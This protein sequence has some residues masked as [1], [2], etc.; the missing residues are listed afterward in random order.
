MLAVM[1]LLKVGLLYVAL[2][3]GAGFVLG[4]F[5]LIPWLVWRGK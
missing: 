2:V 3:F 4:L 1:Q 5:A